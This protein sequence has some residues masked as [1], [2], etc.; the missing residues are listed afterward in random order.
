MLQVPK[1]QVQVRVPVLKTN[2]QV[3]P[4]YTEYRELSSLPVGVYIPH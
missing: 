1:A 3:Q 4:K 2:Y